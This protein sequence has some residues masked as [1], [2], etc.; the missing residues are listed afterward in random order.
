MKRA[1]TIFRRRPLY[2]AVGLEVERNLRAHRAGRDEVRS[3]EG[4]EEVVQRILIRHVDG[5][6][7][8][9]R[10]QMITME[11]VVP[12]GGPVE[13]PAWGHPRGVAIILLGSRLRPRNERG[14]EL[15]ARAAFQPRI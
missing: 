6:Y 3:T 11:N 15:S 5:G 7:A 9:V 8:E 13:H 10:L 14:R 12:T 4:R 1:S 2:C